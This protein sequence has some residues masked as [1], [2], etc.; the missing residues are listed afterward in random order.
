MGSVS[1][2]IGIF[3]LNVIVFAVNRSGSQISRTA[4]IVICVIVVAVI[5]L[6]LILFFCF[7]LFLAITGRTTNEI[8]KQFRG[9]NVRN[10]GEGQSQS[11]NE[12]KNQWLHVDPPLVNLFREVSK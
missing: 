5:A 6:P 11:Q 10:R 1:L 2:T 8:I 3:F 9:Q 7:H 4:V 12:P